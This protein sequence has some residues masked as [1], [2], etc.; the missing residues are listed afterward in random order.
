MHSKSLLAC[1][2]FTIGCGGLAVWA[3]CGSDESTVASAGDGGAGSSSG[4]SS[5]GAT[6]SSGTASSS[7]ASSGGTDGGDGGGSSSGGNPDGGIDPPDAAP[8]GDTTKLACGATTC[9]LP[10]QQCCVGE[11]AGPGDL[12]YGCLTASDGGCPQPAGGGDVTTLKCSGSANCPANTVCC[13]SQVNNGAASECK[14][15]CG[16]N[17]AR[18]CDPSK[19][20]ADGCPNAEQCLNDAAKDWGLPDS[21]GTCDGQGP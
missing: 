10:A 20:N 15:S 19:P 6:S 7:G 1:V 11:V 9:A 12:S 13:V 14:A 4:G 8:G 3:G 17:E 21:Y 16:N 18:L 5:S 2:A